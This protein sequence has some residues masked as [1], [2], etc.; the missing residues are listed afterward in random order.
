MNE[1]RAT[2]HEF[3]FSF[4][5]YGLNNPAKEEDS[6][7][8]YQKWTEL[9][10]QEFKL[11]RSPTSSWYNVMSRYLDLICPPKLYTIADYYL[12]ELFLYEGRQRVEPEFDM[13]KVVILV[14]KEGKISIQK[15]Y[16]EQRK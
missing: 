8:M 6:R 1:L 10:V 15:N 11:W 9:S 16:L 2:I 12:V 14:S 13:A 5:V 7:E 3:L 4:Q